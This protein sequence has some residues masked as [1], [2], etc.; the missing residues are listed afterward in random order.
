MRKTL[1]LQRECAILPGNNNTKS[2]QS[3][4]R[5]FSL[6]LAVSSVV[7]LSACAS[8]PYASRGAYNG[9][10]QNNAAA[11]TLGGALAGAVI[12]DATDGSKTKGALIGAVI[13]GGSCAVP[14]L[15]GCQ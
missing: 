1:P 10:L 3:S 8:D 12:A 4:M 6:L 9:G 5:K 13:G 11:R 14:G 2:R 15:N 7:A